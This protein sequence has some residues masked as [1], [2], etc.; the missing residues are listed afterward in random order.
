MVRLLGTTRWHGTKRDHGLE[1]TAPP[2]ALGPEPI[3]F[4]IRPYVVT[5]PA[6]ILSR[7]AQTRAWW[8]ETN[9][10]LSFT[11]FGFF[12]PSNRRIISWVSQCSS[13][14]GELLIVLIEYSVRCFSRIR[15]LEP[16]EEATRWSCRSTKQPKVMSPDLSSDS[17]RFSMNK[18]CRVHTLFKQWGRVRREK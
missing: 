17:R 14:V 4:E 8:V 15:G 1:P 18:A 3:W 6:G 12:T 5:F 9:S 7:T 11:S 13:R 10:L 2:T 16:K